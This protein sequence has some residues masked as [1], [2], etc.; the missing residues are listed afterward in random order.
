MY[1]ATNPPVPKTLKT[2]SK[3]SRCDL[4]SELTTTIGKL[5]SASPTSAHARAINPCYAA[6]DLRLELVHLLFRQPYCR[7]RD[8]EVEGI[9]KRQTASQYLF[10]M[11]HRSGPAINVLSLMLRAPSQ[12]GDV[13]CISIL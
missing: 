8:L 9:A 6:A 5:A 10:R 4:F 3:S 13:H 12:L 11:L 2:A 1:P 7:I